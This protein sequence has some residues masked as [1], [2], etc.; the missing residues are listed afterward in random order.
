MKASQLR[1]KS[2]EELAQLKEKLA[3]DVMENRFK[4]SIGQLKDK[5]VNR[6]LRRDIARINTIIRERQ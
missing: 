5:A 1:D 2:A 6:K 4:N 3:K